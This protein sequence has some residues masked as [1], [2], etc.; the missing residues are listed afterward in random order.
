MFKSFAYV[1]KKDMLYFLLHQPFSPYWELG[2]LQVSGL[3]LPLRRKNWNIC[4]IIFFLRQS[5]IVTDILLNSLL[6][7][8]FM[9]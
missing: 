2:I 7:T 3:A 4:V 1:L 9:S 6:V 8:S 5:D